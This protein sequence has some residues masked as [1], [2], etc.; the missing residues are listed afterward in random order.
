MVVE[1]VK[2]KLDAVLTVRVFACAIKEHLLSDMRNVE[3]QVIVKIPSIVM[4]RRFHSELI[5][6]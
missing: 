4:N 5:L 1:E 2:G 3:V 6:I